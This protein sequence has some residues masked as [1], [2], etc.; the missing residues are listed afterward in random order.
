MVPRDHHPWALPR[1]PDPS[2][3]D[4]SGRPAGSR[5]NPQPVIMIIAQ[6]QAVALAS[7]GLLHDDLGTRDQPVLP[8]RY[9]LLPGRESRS[10]QRPPA[11]GLG[12]RHV[13]LLGGFV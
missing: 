7:T 9:D 5:H 11:A 6:W 2:R 1:A 13:D 4:P 10:D 3:P 8:V 12:Y